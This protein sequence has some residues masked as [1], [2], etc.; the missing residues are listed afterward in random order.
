[1]PNL[2]S[3]YRLLNWLVRIHYFEVILGITCPKPLEGSPTWV[4]PGTFPHMG[5]SRIV[6]V[7]E[8]VR[9]GSR[10]EGKPT[11]KYYLTICIRFGKGLKTF[12]KIVY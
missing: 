7:R 10:G 2:G 3:E 5:L 9:D 6:E 11:K 12:S 8:G 1:M 4:P